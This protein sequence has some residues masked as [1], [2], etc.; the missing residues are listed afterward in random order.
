[1]QGAKA[2]ADQRAATQNPCKSAEARVQL[3]R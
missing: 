3:R 1:V 2:R